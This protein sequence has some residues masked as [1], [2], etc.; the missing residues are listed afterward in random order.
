MVKKIEGAFQKELVKWI[1]LTY[2]FVD[3]R[4]NKGEGWKTKGEAT[5]DKK[6]GIA[7]AGTPDL[8]LFYHTEEVSY[9]LE[10][11]LKAQRRQ[12]EKNKGLNEAQL[13][14]WSEFKENKNRIG[15]IVYNLH[16]A[17]E[18]INNFINNF[19]KIKY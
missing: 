14:W 5:Q 11:E 13:K 6:M 3:I 8:T 17:Q 18:I 1:K 4:Y 10:L 15:A 12:T 16:T 9:I 19:S 7:K 2:P